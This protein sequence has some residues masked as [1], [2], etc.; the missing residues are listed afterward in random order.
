MQ[1]LIDSANLDEI[2]EFQKLGILDGVTTNP[3]VIAKEK[4][5]F[6]KRIKEI[7]SITDGPISA[8]VTT[9][10]PEKM[11]I[12]ARE[13]FSWSSE[14]INVKIP[15]VKGGLEVISQLSAEG[16]RTNATL[17]FTPNQ[18]LL[19]AKTGADIVSPYVGRQYDI[20]YDGV[21]SIAEIRTIFD[22][23][24]IDT[25]ILGASLRSTRDFVD[26]ASIGVDMVTLTPDLFKKVI[27][28]PLAEEGLDKFLNDWD[29][30]KD[31][32]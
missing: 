22:N 29:R 23:Y 26:V 18:A 12:Q 15:C 3:S 8:Q 25:K 7:I 24:D 5:N 9:R 27:R 6:E 17:V 20:A 2:R 11:L 19:A 1:L 10:K 14:Q 4:V 30:V 13:I 21:E 32:Q 31:L 16:I 28:H